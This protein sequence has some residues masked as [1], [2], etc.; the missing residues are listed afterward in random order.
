M[1]RFFF[2]VA[3]VMHKCF[4][5][6]HVHTLAQGCHLEPSQQLKGMRHFVCVSMATNQ[7]LHRTWAKVVNCNELLFKSVN[8]FFSLFFLP[9]FFLF[10]SEQKS[11]FFMPNAQFYQSQDLCQMPTSLQDL[12]HFIFVLFFNYSCIH[13]FTYFVSAAV[14]FEQL[15]ICRLEFEDCSSKKKKERRHW[16]QTKKDHS[17]WIR[18]AI[19]N[20]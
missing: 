20:F 11:F 7:D 2:F 6:I 3:L 18:K 16:K 19:I 17:E 4:L 13:L 14:G 9:V 8:S 12:L 15:R 1:I 5:H 10:A